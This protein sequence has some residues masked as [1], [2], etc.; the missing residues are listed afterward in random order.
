MQLRE[1]VQVIETALECSV[2]HAPRDVGLTFDELAEIGSRMDIR[3]GEL[4][5]ALIGQ[6][7]NRNRQNRFEH[8]STLAHKFM[9]P[10]MLN[11]DYRPLREMDFIHAQLKEIARDK[12]AAN[13]KIAR[14]V[15]IARAEK[16][17]HSAHDMEVAITVSRIAN[18]IAEA[19][20]I[21]QAVRGME[22]GQPPSEIERQHGGHHRHI[23]TLRDPVNRLV[24][25]VVARRQDGRPKSID[26]LAEFANRLD[27]LGYKPFRLWWMQ[28]LSEMKTADDNHSSVTVSVLAAA[29]MEGALTFIVRHAL[30]LNNGTFSSSDWK[31][32]PNTWR[33]DD[34]VKA[35]AGGGADAI[36]DQPSRSRAEALIRV[37]QRIHA[38]RML[39][40]HP[41]GVQDLR[42]EEARDAR[43]TLELVVRKILD[44]IEAHPR[45]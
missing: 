36:L 25:D 3:E 38:G 4:S 33:V 18:R 20:D 24:A 8:G 23:N 42:P 15:L 35:A 44:W 6:N 21:V 41:A 43:L 19:N 10:G 39:A 34:L 11:P 27:Y 26:T 17:G 28:L 5:D 2:Y 40:D 31:K 32:E 12:G 9:G 29:L 7:Y 22:Q 13:A 14:D 30:S 37:R 1:I 45:S 16:A